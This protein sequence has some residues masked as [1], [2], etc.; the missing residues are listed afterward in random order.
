[1]LRVVILLLFTIIYGQANSQ[2]I[3]SALHLNDGREYRTRRPKKIIETNVFH[4]S[5]GKQVDKNIKIFDDAGM[6]LKEERYNEEGTLTARLTYSND[7]VNRLKFSRTFER[8]NKRGYSRETA[9][10]Y[11]DSSKF[12]VQILDGNENGKVYQTT[13][14][15]CNERGLPIQ[16]TLLDGNGSPFGKEVATYSYEKNR[17]YTSVISN[18]G[19]VLSNDSLTIRV[20]KTN[21]LPDS[22]GTY[23]ANGDLVLWESANLDGTKTIYEEEYDYDKWGNCIENKIYEV[24][25]KEKGKR[26]RKI[27]RVFKKDYIY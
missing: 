20:I 27:D 3:Y 12:L 2:N 19:R 17:V 14:I 8:W 18:D 4:N 25:I 9:F 1:M 5:N 26:K 24:T 6:L 11:Y 15:I 13:E 21:S 10:Y 7:T 23:N 22:T 16:L